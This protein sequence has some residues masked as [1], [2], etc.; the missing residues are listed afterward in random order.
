MYYCFCKAYSLN[1][2]TYLASVPSLL[3]LEVR[4]TPDHLRREGDDIEPKN[5]HSGQSLKDH[6]TVP[7]V[8]ETASR[9]KTQKRLTE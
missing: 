4:N 7:L 8:H 9:Q 5:K 6:G 3:C 1:V 2:C